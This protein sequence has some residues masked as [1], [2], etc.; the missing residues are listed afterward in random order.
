[1]DTNRLLF[2]CITPAGKDTFTAVLNGET[3]KVKRR[4]ELEQKA[5]DSDIEDEAIPEKYEGPK[6]KKI[7]LTAWQK[8]AA[9]Q[10]ISDREQACDSMLPLQQAIILESLP[11]VS[12]VCDACLTLFDSWSE[13]HELCPACVDLYSPDE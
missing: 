9:C 2:S 13:D 1:M 10:R 5:L 12:I 4:L 7:A 6:P 11:Q 3:P 8:M